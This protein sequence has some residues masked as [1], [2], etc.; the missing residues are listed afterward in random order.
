MG[1][2]KKYVIPA[3]LIA[4]VPGAIPLFLYM[5]WLRYKETSNEVVDKK[6]EV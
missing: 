5:L 3:V 6:E 1:N 2:F 4:V